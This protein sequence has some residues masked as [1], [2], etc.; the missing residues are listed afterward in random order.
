[1]M[2]RDYK[3]IASGAYILMLQYMNEI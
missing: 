3:S 2:P 1:M